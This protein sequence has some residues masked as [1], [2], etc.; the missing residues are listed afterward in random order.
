MTA[1]Q[2][3]LILASSQID[4]DCLGLGITRQRGL[5]KLTADTRFLESTERKGV[6]KGV[7]GV[8]PD[9]SSL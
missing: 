6:M 5:P 8:D 9:G 7:V 2:Y 3:D 4:A 1:V